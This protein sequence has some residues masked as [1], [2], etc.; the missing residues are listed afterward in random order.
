MPRFGARTWFF[1]GELEPD[2]LL[3]PR[4]AEREKADRRGELEGMRQGTVLKGR[5]M[6]REWA[7]VA[8]ERAAS[9]AKKEAAR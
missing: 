5:L 2:P 3:L 8:A 4:R 6:R 1:E 9:E 7:I